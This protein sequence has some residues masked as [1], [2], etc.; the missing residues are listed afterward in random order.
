MK[1]RVLGVGLDETHKASHPG[2]HASQRPG[3]RHSHPHPSGVMSKKG[4]V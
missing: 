2:S 3:L 1:V 4:L